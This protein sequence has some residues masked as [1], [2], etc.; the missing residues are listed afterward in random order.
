MATTPFSLA[1]ALRMVPNALLR[2]YFDKLGHEEFDLVWEELKERDVDPVIQYVELLS[3]EERDQIESGLHSVS[4]LASDAGLNV[5]FQAAT[6]SGC[7]EM[8]TETPDKLGPWG[9]A[10]WI[11]LH[12]PRIFEKGEILLRLDQMSFWR[13]RTD[14]PNNT[15][16]VSPVAIEH[17]QE[18]ISSLLRGQGRGRDCTV[19]W[20]K[21][22]EMFY[23]FAHPDDFVCN[24]LVHDKEGRLA[25]KAI[26]QTLDIVFAY[27]PASE[28]LELFAKSLPKRYK[29]RLEVIF[30]ET[31]LHGKIDDYDPQ[32]AYEL[33]HLKHEFIYL[34]TDPADHV[35]VRIR[36]L[37]L[38][39]RDDRR[40]VEIT[41]DDSNPDE[42]IGKAIRELLRIEE[43]PLTQWKVTFATFRFIFHPK[44]GRKHGRQSFDV[45][46]PRS[47]S[48]RNARPERIE[49]IQKYLKK[50]N[51]D[52][53]EPPKYSVDSVGEF[54]ST[55][56][57]IGSYPMEE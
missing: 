37:R 46:Y 42:L 6:D 12:Y 3:S 27:D 52:L 44:D 47:C 41:I 7:P 50:W 4:D 51:I 57:G 9:K 19:E 8:I 26:R 48:L 11:W 56:P 5:L 16:D 10:M 34:K 21:R 33:D 45:G 30:A 54:K 1:T 20:L 28:S 38:L 49:L 31:I 35:N 17:L 13:K 53:A 55:Y 40:T 24:I 43:R 23:F 18:E 2:K 22:G 36:R 15:P 25:P 32:A 14:L 29:E 39:H